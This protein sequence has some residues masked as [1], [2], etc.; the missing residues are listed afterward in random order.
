MKE[1][2]KQSFP[3]FTCN[4]CGFESHFSFIML[5]HIYKVHN[6]RPSKNDIKNAIKYNA[7]VKFIMILISLFLGLIFFTIGI[8]TAPFSRLKNKIGNIFFS[9]YKEQQLKV[10][11]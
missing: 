7:F 10:R 4:K 8:I 11:G 2:L 1:V 9:K 6:L 5:W 3:P